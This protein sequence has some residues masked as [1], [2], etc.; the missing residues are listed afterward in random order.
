MWYHKKM[1]NWIYKNA[2]HLA[3]IQ[4][5][6][7]T[8]GSLYFSEVKGYTPCVLCWYQRICMYA[9]VP[10]LL[11]GF[12]RGDKK[13]YHFVVPLAFMGWII[14]VYHNLLYTGI[15]KP[16][17]TCSL[18]ISCTSKYIEYWGF[19]TIPFLSLAAFSIILIC[20]VLYRRWLRKVST[21][22]NMVQ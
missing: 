5:I 8:V 12:F 16:E 11:T 6:I 9:L 17:D 4:A 10:V 14:A 22:Q 1:K 18:G 13:V 21:V 15:I 19:V 3:L 7:A 2:L 20:T